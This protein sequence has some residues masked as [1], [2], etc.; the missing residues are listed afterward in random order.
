MSPQEWPPGNHLHCGGQPMA[1][2]K[3]TSHGYVYNLDPWEGDEMLHYAV[4]AMGK[5][6]PILIS[7]SNHIMSLA[8][9][10][11]STEGRL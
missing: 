7:Y 6:L 11:N 5:P 1:P 3:K 9:S 4:D 2:K 10:I 8:I